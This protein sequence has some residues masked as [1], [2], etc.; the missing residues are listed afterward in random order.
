MIKEEYNI[1]IQAG[2]SNIIHIMWYH[3]STILQIATVI[4][5]SYLTYNIPFIVMNSFIPLVTNIS[6][7][8][9]LGLNTGL[10]IFDMLFIPICGLYTQKHSPTMIMKN[11]CL[12]LAITI[13]PLWHGLNDAPLWYVTAVRLG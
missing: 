13:I 1:P 10:L 4:S 7:S 2:Y 9:M 8:T 12:V 11:S 3:K 5:F 6:S